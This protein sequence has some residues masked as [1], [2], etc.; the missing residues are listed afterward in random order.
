MNHTNLDDML[1]AV[2]VAGFSLA[3]PFSLKP[4]GRRLA[5][6]FWTTVSRGTDD[7]VVTINKSKN[8]I[9]TLMFNNSIFLHINLEP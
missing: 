4:G 8:N 6:M 5:G 9:N 1:E 3:L 2:E 7:A